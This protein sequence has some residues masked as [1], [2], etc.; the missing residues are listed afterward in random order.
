MACSNPILFD[1]TG[2]FLV[3]SIC[4]SVERSATWFS[5]EAPAAIKKVPVTKG[6]ESVVSL[7][8]DTIKPT[9]AVMLTALDTF[10]FANVVKSIKRG[11]KAV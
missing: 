3:R 8:V 10:S 11:F 6:M 2:L 1:A 9:S 7:P 4:E 5:A